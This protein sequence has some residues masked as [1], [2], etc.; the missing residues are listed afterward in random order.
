MICCC[1]L[2]VGIGSGAGESALQD[3]EEIVNRSKNR[4][5]GFIDIPLSIVGYRA[6]STIPTPF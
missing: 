5:L 6:N 2:T 3:T 4:I 1:G